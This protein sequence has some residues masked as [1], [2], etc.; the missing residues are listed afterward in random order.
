MNNKILVS[1]LSLIK[2]DQKILDDISLDLR[3][4]KTYLIYGR[5][6][7]GKTSLFKCLLGLEKRFDGIINFPQGTKTYLPEDEDIPDQILVG[8]YLKSFTEILKDEGR[9]LPKLHEFLS[10]KFKINTFSNK[11]FGEISKG[12]KKLIFITIALI[13]NSELVVLDEPFEGLDIINKEILVEI[14]T[15]KLKKDRIV[16]LSSHEIGGINKRFD[17]LISLKEGRITKFLDTNSKT[18]YKQILS[19]I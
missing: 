18:T 13:S 11:Y 8:D 1:N 6:G 7:A 4:G 2:K 14:L 19:Y 12:M 10:K 3:V 15:N 5:N 17:Y 16:L 9:Y